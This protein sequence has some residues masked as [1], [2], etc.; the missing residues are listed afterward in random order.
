MRI[1]SQSSSVFG[2]VVTS[3]CLVT[4]VLTASKMLSASGS[5]M[6]RISSLTETTGVRS[7]QSC[8]AGGEG[9]GAL[10]DEQ[11]DVRTL[12]PKSATNMPNANRMRKT[13]TTAPLLRFDCAGLSVRCRGGATTRP[14][15][16]TR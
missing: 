9:G 12:R 4:T 14:S 13:V 7:P 2:T 6:S 10:G 8:D 3:P 15:S 5:S 1:F 11:V 16:R